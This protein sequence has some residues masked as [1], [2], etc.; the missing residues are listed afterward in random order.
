MSSIMKNMSPSHFVQHAEFHDKWVSVPPVSHVFVCY[1]LR[2]GLRLQSLVSVS[3]SFTHELSDFLPFKVKLISPRG[4]IFFSSESK[5]M[6]IK[7]IIEL[8]DRKKDAKRW[9]H[10]VGFNVNDWFLFQTE[11]MVYYFFSSPLH[12]T[13]TVHMYNKYSTFHISSASHIG[14]AVRR[15]R[16]VAHTKRDVGCVCI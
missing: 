11:E 9:C 3:S 8:A 5:A 10:V 16:P 13:I 2:V 4:S 12:A 14:K 6:T 15:R 7:S 1:G